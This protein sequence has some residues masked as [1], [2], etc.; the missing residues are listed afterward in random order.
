[1]GNKHIKDTDKSI[2]SPTTTHQPSP[3]I[4][5]G[6]SID[7]SIFNDKEEK[8]QINGNDK[9]KDTDIINKCQCLQRTV[10]CL[11]YYEALNTKNNQNGQYEFTQFV[12]DNIL[13]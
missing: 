9:D 10:S 11:R 7:F 5:Q 2:A 8:C 3:T 6:L 1:M 12:M 13:K 4:K